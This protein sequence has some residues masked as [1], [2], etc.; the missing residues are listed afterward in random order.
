MTISVPWYLERGDG[1][2][3]ATAIH[4]GSS[5]RPELAALMQLS[6]EERLREEDSCTGDWTNVAPTRLI[7]QLS[8]FEVDLNR[9]K[10]KAVYLTPEDAWGLKVWKEPLSSESQAKSLSIYDAFYDEVREILE[11]MVS[12]YRRVVVLDLHTYNHRREGATGPLA[13]AK[14]NPEVNIGTATMNRSRWAPIVD[15]F[16]VDLRNF[17]YIGRHLDVREN[18]KFQG[19]NF[20]R[21]IHECFP[22]SVCVLSVE[23]KK[24]FMDEWTGEPD[25]LQVQAIERALKSTVWGIHEELVK[26]GLTE[27]EISA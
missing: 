14:E 3:V 11:R 8:R 17:E 9:P 10:E 20:A 27:R 7:G 1:P 5:V 25:Q 26:L 2:I 22:N 24:F 23:F 21:W 6:N 12:R 13:D 15:R 18:I 4:D 19:G 16:I